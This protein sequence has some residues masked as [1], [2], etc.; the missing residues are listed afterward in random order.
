[1]L[2][3]LKTNRFLPVFLTQFLG[4]FNDNLL[5]NALVILIAFS[6][7]GILGM[8][9]QSMAALAVGIFILP[10]F[11]FSSIAGQ[12]AD[13]HEKSRLISYL[14]A[15]EI[16]L[17]II[18][19]LGLII[20]SI[21]LLLFVLFLMGTQSA[22]FGPLKYGIL[23]DHLRQDELPGGNALVEASTF[24]SI[25]AGTILGGWLILQKEGECLIASLV[26]ITAIA[27][28]IA[29]RFIPP[30]EINDPTLSFNYNLAKETWDI[31]K[32]T[33][34]NRNVFPS[35]AGISW[36]WLIGVIFLSQLPNYIKN[37]LGA[38]G[39]TATLFL[40]VFS[41]GIGLGSFLSKFFPQRKTYAPGIPLGALG[42]SIFT[43]DLY[44]A[45]SNPF[46]H[47]GGALLNPSLFLKSPNHWR[48]LFDLLMV[49][50][51]G[52]IYSVPLYTILQEQSEPERRARNISANNIMN[53]FFMVAGTVL[54]GYALSIGF[55]FE[56][57]FLALGVFNGA[58]AIYMFLEFDEK[59]VRRLMRILFRIIYRVEITGLE[60]INK[61]NEKALIAANHVSFLDGLLIMA[62]LP[63]RMT[64][65]V[66]TIIARRWW[67][68]P[69][70]GFSDA[71]SIDPAN[72][73]SIRTLMNRINQNKRVVIFPEGR[74]TVTGSLMKIYNGPGMIAYKSKA[75][76]LPVRI[77][78]AQYTPFSR[79][80]GLCPK[81]LF[82]KITLTVSE[83]QYLKISQDIK[84]RE[85]RRI[86][87]AKLYEMLAESSFEGKN[88]HQTLFQSLLDARSIYGPGH[89]ICEDMERKPLSYR[90]L[91]L[92]IFIL[93]K[94]LSKHVEAGKTSGLLLPN[95]IN[96][97]IAFFALQTAAGI[98]A[99]LNYSSGSRNIASACKT[100][101]IKKV[102][103]SRKFIEIAKLE[104]ITADLIRDGI[105]IIYLEDLVKEISAI[106][107]L[108]GL[109]SAQF[110]NF[111]HNNFHPKA[112]P[113]TPAVVLFTSGSEGTPKGV[114]LSHVN[115]QSNRHQL[116]SR[117]DLNCKDVL[118]NAL[119]LFHS[120]GLTGGMLMPLLSG[121]KTIFFP[122][123][124][125]YRII[126]EM[127]YDTCA[128]ILFG[129]DTFLAGYGK[130][131]HPYDFY[132]LRYV[133][134]GAE[135]LKE[136]TQQLWT[137]K[138]GKRI[139]EGYGATETSPVISLNT[140]M[141][142]KKNSV[143]TF[144]PG[145]RY[146]LEKVPGI[147]MGG[148]LI[149]Y[150]PN[151]MSGYLLSGDPGKVIPPKGGWHDTGDIVEVDEEGYIFIKGRAKRF[152]KI[153][154]EMISL[155]AVEKN[156]SGLWP[157]EGHIVLSFPDKKKGEQLAL[158]TTHSTANRNSISKHF[159]S[160]G[161]TELSLPKKIVA[162][163]EIPLLATGKT[164]YV[165]AQKILNMHLE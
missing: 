63:G 87:G 66:N 147:E 35:I 89:I 10:F 123:P 131:A 84:G 142:N 5:K 161:L 134:A 151:I 97:V 125:K 136:E 8:T 31:I 120:F 16:I 33:R 45:G 74:L 117:I 69:L 162:L 112:D 25:L 154:G 101:K 163:D 113:E 116:A 51:C 23:P 57:L 29:S 65:A 52:G 106:E 70:L 90:M 156:I 15:V 17:M 19:A 152:A 95:A 22:F 75:Q 40:T 111:Y 49:S 124:L 94:A 153:A 143:G 105:K 7:A 135:K 6:Q 81:I 145:I 67:I 119:P 133:F 146:K 130:S 47:S 158:L 77:E 141:Q 140:L 99:W 43:I 165:S 109:L 78:G 64:F 72:P 88:R 92:K 100:A 107:K 55:T 73:H 62:F 121:I 71:V 86:A 150:G 85:R 79:L 157:T 122:S 41:I 98:P 76:I 13:K 28:W 36:F 108:R 128:T 96:S 9:P 80:K 44:F 129:T 27:G 32:S 21:H 24:I 68:K 126:P 127:A 18:A 20:E 144:L 60:N 132:N 138:L 103:A 93:G 114:A 118:F 61:L 3:L 159:I 2:S 11:I 110:P 53:A 4:A 59:G 104:G 14:K 46:L 48:L 50:I 155:S 58:V 38:D 42:I 102:I 34:N 137:E 83:P 12:L 82:P 139:L 160:I 149:V 91:I 148:R 39:H 1:M 115:L 37:N 164:D 56:Q 26:V 30:A 54:S